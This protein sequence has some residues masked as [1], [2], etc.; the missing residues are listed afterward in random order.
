[1]LSQFVNFFE[2]LKLINSFEKGLSK[3]PAYLRNPYLFLFREMN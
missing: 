2:L 3:R 1:M